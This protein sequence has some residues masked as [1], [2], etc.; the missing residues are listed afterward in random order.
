[1]GPGGEVYVTYEVFFARG[2]RRHFVAKSTD[3]GQTF[4]APVPV[5]PLFHDLSFSSTYRKNSFSALAVSPSNGNV[6]V[7]Y[8]DEPNET[9]GA[10][11]EFASSS[12]GGATFSSPAVINDNSSGEQF[13]PAVTVD[14]SGV[15][16]ASWFDTRN[17]PTTTSLYDIFAT[18]SKDAGT[19]FAPNARVTATLVN[20]DSVPFIGDYAGIAAGGGFAHSVWTSGGVSP[21]SKGLLET[22]A[23]KLP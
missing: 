22:A 21:V 16:H 15:I 9:V 23:L 5:T 19:T 11:V 12:D 7:V 13:F 14:S 4:S 2:L 1:V 3:G 17:S 6:Y 8:A 20:A 10:E 18:F